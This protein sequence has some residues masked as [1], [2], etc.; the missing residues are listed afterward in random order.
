[1]SG[2]LCHGAGRSAKEVLNVSIFLTDYQILANLERRCKICGFRKI[3]R[4]L[5][6]DIFG[7]SAFRDKTI[8][9]ITTY[10]LFIIFAP[11]VSILLT[12]HDNIL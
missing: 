6:G 12:M 7:N 3:A 10:Y 2:M 4:S 1:L 5:V 8:K 9:L 11:L